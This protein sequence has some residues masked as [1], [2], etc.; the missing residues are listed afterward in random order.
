[1]PDITTK[2]SEALFLIYL[3]AR[4][5]S[6]GH[7]S[8]LTKLLRWETIQYGLPELSIRSQRQIS[9]TI[10]THLSKACQDSMG[11]EDD[12]SKGEDEMGGFEDLDPWDWLGSYSTT[13]VKRAYGVQLDIGYAKSEKNL[14]D[15]TSTV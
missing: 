6:R 12:E 2:A 13:T 1:M 15:H 11:F 9:I 10:A 7:S 8:E 4:R 14:V 3:W 5:V